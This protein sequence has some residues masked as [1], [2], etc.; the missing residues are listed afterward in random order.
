[1]WFTSLGLSLVSALI[2]MLAKQWIAGYK[3][4]S[5]PKHVKNTSNV[6]TQVEL[7]FSGTGCSEWF[8]EAC[9]VRQYVS[10]SSYGRRLY[11]S[12]KPFTAL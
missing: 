6:S 10:G 5:M 2:A 1:M 8:H 9:R 12:Q 11:H 7:L 3:V 4:K